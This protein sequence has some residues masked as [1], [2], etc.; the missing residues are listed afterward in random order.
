MTAA[1]DPKIDCATK[2]D[3]ASYRLRDLYWG[4][5]SDLGF[6]FTDHLPH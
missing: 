3:E 2:F 6:A 5:S 1:A 4:S